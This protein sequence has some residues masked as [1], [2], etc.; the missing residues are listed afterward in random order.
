MEEEIKKI[1][2]QYFNIDNLDLACFDTTED[3]EKLTKKI[4]RP[5]CSARAEV[6]YND[7]EPERNYAHEA[8]VKLSQSISS[9]KDNLIREAINHVLQRT[10]WIIEEVKDRCSN[11][12]MVNTF[13]REE[14]FCIDGKRMILFMPPEI[15]MNSNKFTH[16]MNYKVLYNG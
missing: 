3:V 8:A 5:L 14:Y 6:N 9:K 12:I 2:N 15:A 16:T 4:M 10:D 13:P 7:I 11:E 1:L